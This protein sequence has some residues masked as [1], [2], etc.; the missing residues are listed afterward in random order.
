MLVNKNSEA[1][2]VIDEDVLVTSSSLFESKGIING[3]VYVEQDSSFELHGILNGSLKVDDSSTAT[4][5]GIA[6][7][8]SVETSTPIDVYGIVKCPINLRDRF[9]LHSGARFEGI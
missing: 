5:H 1:N 3:N 6:C 2:C 7:L 9:S 4:I 8:K